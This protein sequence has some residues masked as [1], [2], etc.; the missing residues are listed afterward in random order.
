MKRV[1]YDSKEAESVQFVVC[2]RVTDL[3]IPLKPGQIEHCRDC[4]ERIWVAHS[5]PKKP[6]RV[7][8]HC[9]VEQL[10]QGELTELITMMKPMN[11][12]GPMA[13]MLADLERAA[14][15]KKQ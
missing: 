11:P 2:M 9:V 14:E 13:K 7:C 4:S 6:P 12:H 10:D 1:R 3:P 5:S 15:K 8:H